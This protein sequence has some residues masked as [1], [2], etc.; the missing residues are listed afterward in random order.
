[1]NESTPT[2]ETETATQVSPV[3]ALAAEM[4]PV[5]IKVQ[6]GKFLKSSFR[7]LGLLLGLDLVL[8]V[9]SYAISDY[10]TV[11]TFAQISYYLMFPIG[12]LSGLCLSIYTARVNSYIHELEQASTT[13]LRKNTYFVIIL[14]ASIL[15]PVVISRSDNGNFF[16]ALT[17]LLGIPLAGFILWRKGGKSYS[18]W[19]KFLLYGLAAILGVLPGAIAAFIIAF[20]LSDRACSLSSSK[21]Y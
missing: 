6:F 5:A 12:I 15:V 16:F 18:G 2:V 1:M 9:S 8:L 19:Q 7:F 11:N 20:V 10:S 14:A 13:M 4:S 3:P 21:C 17:I